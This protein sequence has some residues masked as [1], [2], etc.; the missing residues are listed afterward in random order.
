MRFDGCLC[1]CRSHQCQCVEKASKKT[2]PALRT[3]KQ[4][5][6]K[7]KKEK[8]KKQKQKQSNFGTKVQN[9]H[10]HTQQQKDCPKK[11]YVQ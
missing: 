10:T 2:Y 7:D 4:K 1:D 3:K 5:Q 11:A 8:E 9:T 6:K